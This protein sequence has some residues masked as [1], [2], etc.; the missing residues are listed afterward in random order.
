LVVLG[1]VDA[2]GFGIDVWLESLDGIRQRRQHKWALGLLRGD[3]R[4]TRKKG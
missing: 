2:H 1:V 3:G 4:K